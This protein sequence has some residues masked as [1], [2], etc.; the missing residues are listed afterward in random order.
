MPLVAIGQVQEIFEINGFKLCV[1]TRE[2]LVQNGVCDTYVS[3]LSVDRNKSTVFEES[4]CASY[5]NDVTIIR[6]GYLSIVEHY[7][8]PVGW[9]IY[10]IFNFCES[11]VF[12]TRRISDSDKTNLNWEDFIEPSD[13]ISSEYI[14]KEDNL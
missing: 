9:S 3:E 5:D 11:R 2:V 8:S 12:Q 4:I 6:K 7:S 14:I 1:Q 13:E 10:Y